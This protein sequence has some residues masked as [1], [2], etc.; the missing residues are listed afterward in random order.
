M[1]GIYVKLDANFFDDPKVIEAGEPAAW[2]YLETLAMS[3]RM[4]TDGRISESQLRRVRV[5]NRAR[6]VQQLL[7]V[8]LW[9][10]TED[11]YEIVAYL[12]HNKSAGA[13]AQT[14]EQ[15]KAAG[16]KANH[17]RWHVSPPRPAT[18]CEFCHPSDLGSDSESGS[19]RGRE[20]TE[21][22]TES[23]TKTDDTSAGSGNQGPLAQTGSSSSPYG[24][25]EAGMRAAANRVAARWVAET[26]KA[27]KERGYAKGV[28][29]GFDADHDLETVEGQARREGWTQ[30]QVAD[31][32]DPPRKPPSRLV[33]DNF[34]RDEAGLD[35]PE[36]S[37]DELDQARS[38]AA[39][40]RS[41][42]GRTPA[43]S[44]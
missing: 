18:D 43:L 32:F 23:E 24:P 35:Q 14:S 38:M 27:D 13:I 4:M 26:G 44:A 2:L 37:A 40:A 8:G 30:D 7:K 33:V 39:A 29:D 22:K 20:S 12:K 16:R 36:P 9:K 21:T 19:D 5:H 17:E 42:L 34:D 6:R 28:L 1:A 31:F 41:A 3:K 10:R 11:G 15:R 25:F